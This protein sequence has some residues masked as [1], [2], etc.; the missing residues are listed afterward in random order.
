M[1]LINALCGQ[2]LRAVF[3]LR[4]PSWCA[5]LT[6]DNK[7]TGQYNLKLSIK[8]ADAPSLRPKNPSAQPV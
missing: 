8:T 3:K 6:Y 4:S 1:A 7:D 5:A 2:R